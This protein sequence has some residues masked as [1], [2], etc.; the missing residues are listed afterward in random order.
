MPAWKNIT[1]NIPKGD[2]N[3]ISEK[4]SEINRVLSIT[5]LDR[6]NEVDSRWFDENEAIQDLDGKTHLIRLLTSAS[7]DSNIINKDICKKIDVDVIEVL[8]EEIFEDRDWIQY[9]KS[10]FR[11]IHITNN[12]TVLPPWVVDKNQNGVSIII[13]PG[14]GFGTGS[15]PTTK[16]CLKWI[17]NNISS[18]CQIL[19]YGCGSGILSIAAEKLGC[20]KV[21]GIDNDHQALVNAERNKTLN[22]SNVNF[23]HSDNYIQKDEYDITVANILLNTIVLLKEKLVSS[24]KPGGTLILSGIL[25]DQASS[26][27]DTFRNE[28]MI[29]IIDQKEGWLLMKGQK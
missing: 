3:Q 15:H 18:D 9:S 10:Q 22:S 17:D 12:L 26:I 23:F 11:E 14:S 28:M 20:S 27:I 4:I 21:D 19:D 13:E 2:L 25:E 16:L 29:R 8:N 5:I 1:L 24:L 7:V 6:T